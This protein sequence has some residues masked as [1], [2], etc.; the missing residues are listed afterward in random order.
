M[1][2]ENFWKQLKHG[3]LHNH[4]RPRLDQLIWI[5]VTQVTPAYLAR[6]EVLSDGYRLGRSKPPTHFQK[7]FK[8]AWLKLASLTPSP[9]ANK[10]YNTRVDKWTCQCKSQKFHSCHLCKHLVD[11]VGTP[12][13]K[14]WTEVVR[15]RTM[16]L[17]RHPVL[18]PR[19][20]ERASYIEPTDGSIT[21]GDDHA[22]SSN[23]KILAGGGGWR[24][25]DF[26]TTSLLGK[27]PRL[28]SQ[29]SD[30]DSSAGDAEEVQRQFFP[31]FE[32]HDSDDEEQVSALH[33]LI[34]LCALFILFGGR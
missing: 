8:S 34:I 26:N 31:S 19:G 4:L 18:V 17:Y 3:F 2:V 7:Q 13:P 23:S 25:L 12:P 10:K 21:D 6:A 11:A 29:E 33:N 30:S 9:D 5:L 28:S 20:E 1:N 24:D 16:P 22:W 32:T 27:R 14:F 15:R